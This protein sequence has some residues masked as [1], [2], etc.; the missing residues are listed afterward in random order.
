MKRSNKILL[1]LATLWPFAY[2]ILFFFIIF[3][4]IFFVF[5]TGDQESGPPLFFLLIVPLHL[6]TMIWMIAL[7]VFYMVNV[8]KNDRVD[9]DKKVL[10]AVVIFM[11][12][13]IAMPIY[14]Y[15]Y[16]WKEAPDSANP[17]PLGSGD[18]SAWTNNA[19]ASTRQQA[20]APPREAPN[21]RE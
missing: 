7:T 11:G 17:L 13:M 8:F 4:S 10:W 12:N 9:K 1:G 15:L 16:F 5:N 18:T 2:L 6:L 20:Y 19:N 3:G 14:W 21:W